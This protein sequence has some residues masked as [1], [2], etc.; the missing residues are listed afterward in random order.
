M[1]RTRETAS[2][3]LRRHMGEHLGPFP[4]EIARRAIL[5]AC[6]RAG[7]SECR[8]PRERIVE[9]T[10]ELDPTR[11]QAKR[12]MELA[13][14]AGLTDGA[15]RR[16][17]C[18]RNLRRGQGAPGAERNGPQRG[19]RQASG[20]GGE[21]SARRLLSRVH[22]WSARDGRLDQ[23]RLAAHC[24][25]RGSSS[26]HSWAAVPRSRQR[27]NSLRP[28]SDQRPYPK[29]RYR[30]ARRRG[31]GRFITMAPTL[32]PRLPPHTP[33]AFKRDHTHPA[34]RHD[35]LISRHMT[36]ICHRTRRSRRRRSGRERQHAGGS[37]DG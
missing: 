31:L 34:V 10:A 20:C 21:A 12:A 33:T 28:T 25:L 2:I 7:V 9:R 11:P 29:H 30:G 32:K 26:I 6:P 35:R 23:L 14:E 24:K 5:F 4:T 15:L 27:L 19:A 17:S 1:A 18:A 36:A 8:K 37:E 22:V 16:D 13:N 3:T